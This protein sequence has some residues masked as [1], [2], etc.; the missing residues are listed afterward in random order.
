MV[1][2]E[3]ETLCYDQW[4]AFCTEQGVIPHK[5]YGFLKGRS[6][7]WLLLTVTQEWSYAIDHHWLSHAVFLDMAKAFD[8]VD[9]QV[10]L[11]KLKAFGLSDLALKWFSS[12]LS[13][14]QI[15]TRVADVRS[16]VLPINSGVPQGSVLGPLLFI[17]V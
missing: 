12:F 1:S 10:L 3:S 16:A 5:Q 4:L 6:T 11:Y 7:E 8:Q 17:V 14:R 13:G 9:H 2:K 15:S